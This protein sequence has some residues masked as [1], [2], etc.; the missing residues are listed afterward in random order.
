M[1]EF[2]QHNHIILQYISVFVKMEFAQLTM[3]MYFWLK[4]LILF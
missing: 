1:Y 2:G 3:L 4:I